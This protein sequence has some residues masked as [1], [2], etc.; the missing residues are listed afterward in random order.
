VSADASIDEVWEAEI[1]PTLTEYIRIPALSPAFDPDWAAHGHLHEA[2]ELLRGWA[3]SR[4]IDGLRLEVV[5]LPGRTPLLL[6]EIPPGGASRHPGD[7]GGSGAPGD[8]ESAGDT[9]LLYG[10]LDKQPEMTG[11]RDGLGP[12]V[13]VR[14]GDRLYGRGGA[15]DGYSMFAALAAIE[16]ARRSHRPHARCVL[17][18]EASEESGSIDLPAYVDALA[19]RLGP[20][21]LVVCL[22]SGCADYDRLWLTTSLRGLTG[23]VLD[24]R[25]ATEGL[26]SGAYGGV[27]PSTFRITRLL[28]D[29]VEDPSS[30]RVLLPEAWVDIP[31]ERARQADET[32]TILGDPTTELPLV[33]GAAI[34]AG[35]SD[36]EI[37]LDRTWRPS[38]EVIGADGLPAVAHAG[39]VLRP[40]TALALSLRLPPGADPAAARDALAGAL[41]G[42]PPYGAEVRFDAREAA[43]GW[44]APPT[45]PWLDHAVQS[46]SSAHFGQRAAAMGE[47]GTIPFM[48][49]L[50]ERFPEAQFL[51]VGV[52]GPGAN[53]H[54]PNEFLH[55]P[56]A[57]RLTACVADVLAAHAA[58]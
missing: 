1:L 46:A 53:A 31:A 24:V 51:V 20:V 19:P 34:R 35:R 26:H 37:L 29:R 27:L 52:L 56:T 8:A 13:P 40:R 42:D 33:A 7:S 10:H 21:S 11:W 17:M 49:M 2:T 39:N 9:V 16:A 14:D 55:V 3:A 47:G 32:A 12:W 54:G 57:K 25:V 50:G 44:D 6:A 43:P 48:G 18:I 22:D 5:E 41:T 58:R 45:A 23:G 28:L 38:L 4:R 15:D 36:A 30:G